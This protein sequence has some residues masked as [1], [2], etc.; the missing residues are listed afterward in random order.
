MN[1]E[2]YM[3]ITKVAKGLRKADLVLKNVNVINVFS[4][5]IYMGDIA[6][7]DGVVAGVGQYSGT[8]EIDLS[9]F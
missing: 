2:R 7:C 3:H 1:V 4:E 8:E 5:E 9:G 6:I